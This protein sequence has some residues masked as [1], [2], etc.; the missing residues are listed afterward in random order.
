[1]HIIVY[2]PSCHTRYQLDP[3]LRGQHMRCPN[4]VCREV[5]E[6]QEAVETPPDNGQNRPEADSDDGQNGPA[7][8]PVPAA[9]RP[10]SGNVADIL[11]LLPAEQVEQAPPAPPLAS[12]AD[13]RAG[14]RSPR[15][16]SH[17]QEILPLL[18]AEA[19]APV[20][21]AAP[22]EPAA[23]QPSSPAAEP[24]I[25]VRNWQEAPPPLR[26]AGASPPVEPVPEAPPSVPPPPRRSRTAPPVE[27]AALAPPVTPPPAPPPAPMPAMELP[28]TIL[29]E[30]APASG[31]GPTE[32]LPGQWE[33]PPVR[34]PVGPSSPAG[35]PDARET[36]DVH[37]D[38]GTSAPGA[39]DTMVAFPGG[40]LELPL[41]PPEGGPVAEAAH[42]GLPASPAAAEHHVAVARAARRRNLRFIGL[43]V[44][45]LLLGIGVVV[46][47]Y[48]KGREHTLDEVKADAKKA[49]D[50]GN[51]SEA[52]KLY[53]QLQESFPDN[54]DVPTWAFMEQLAK[55][56]DHVSRASAN[57][58]ESADE[59]MQFI[60]EHEKDPLLEEFK[61][62]IWHVVG[63]LIEDLAKLS[64][65]KLDP[66]LLDQ[67]EKLL[68][69]LAKFM[70]PAGDNAPFLKRIGGTRVVLAKEE[71]RKRII[72]YL[73]Q[74]L[75]LKTLKAEDVVD[76]RHVV[77]KEGLHNDREAKELLDQI[78]EAF[79]KQVVYLEVKEGGELPRP[80][81][82]DTEPALLVAPPVGSYHSDLA[83]EG[84]VR[85]VFALARGVLW[86]LDRSDGHVRW[87]TRV[88]LD[89]TTLPI[90]LPAKLSAPERVLVL[91][92]DTNT[93]TARD[94]LYGKALW[95]HR[96]HAPCLSRPVIVEDRAYIPTITGRI[97]EI[98]IV[99]GTLLGWYQLG[100]R[101]IGGIHQE[102]T[103]LIY[104]PAESRSIYVIDVVKK[105]CVTVLQT[106]HP[107]A[108]LR[109]EPVIVTWEDPDAAQPNRSS[110]PGYLILCQTDGLDAMK[111][112]V[113]KLPITDAKAA[114]LVEQRIQGWSSLPPHC[115]GES[116]LLATDAGML[117]LFGIR[118]IRNDDPP[119]FPR[120]EQINTGRAVLPGEVDLFPDLPK[121][122]HLEDQMRAGGAQVIPVDETDFCALVR[123]EL[124]RYRFDPYGQKVWPLWRDPVTQT[125]LPLHLGSPLHGSQFD[126]DDQTLVVV[127]QSPT[128]QA[129]LAT[130]VD[131]R[132]GKIH[133]QRQLGLVCQSE[134]R[135]VVEARPEFLGVLGL[136]P[137]A[138]LP[139]AVPW[140]S[141]FCAIHPGVRL[142]GLD[143]GGGLFSY[144][145][146]QFEYRP[147]E[148]WQ[149][150]SKSL[151]NVLQKPKTGPIHLLRGPG[152]QTLYAIAA[153]LDPANKKYELWVQS[154]E[155][156][157]PSPKPLV[158]ELPS[159]LSGT[160][161]LLGDAL[162]L[163]LADGSLI[164]QPLQ[165]R[166][167]S[168][169]WPTWRAK[170]AHLRSLGHVVALGDG[171]FVTTDG[172]RT[173]T[174]WRPGKPFPI[175]KEKAELPTQIGAPPVLVP[176]AEGEPVPRVCVAD[177]QG[178]VILLRGDDL[179]MLQEWRLGEMGGRVTAGP[180]VREKWIGCIVDHRRLVWLDPAQAKPVWAYLSQEPAHVLGVSTLG[181]MGLHQGAG[182]LAATAALAP[183][184]TGR[185]DIVGHPQ[186]VGDRLLVADES[187]RFV[188]LDP[189]TG[190]PQGKGYTLRASVAPAV[191]PVSFGPDRAFAPL[192]DGTVL[193]LSL[194]HFR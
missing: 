52:G 53:R 147:N 172:L 86:A 176:P 122:P 149:L 102:E 109:S 113:F 157:R 145:S 1:V 54:D 105:E 72:D 9:P 111:L 106:E 57:P 123:G 45:A 93:L 150:S 126:E 18:D 10:M 14:R 184:R 162:V 13:K 20:E 159:A 4:P 64:E 116:L 56:R 38:E 98:E 67:A 125:P 40:P 156:G 26:F 11:P 79:R 80:K 100:E 89:M 69:E 171:G 182:P 137:D 27:P 158:F 185:G 24:P 90:R 140:A 74:L 63:K 42:P 114:P 29:P 33:A 47:A 25:E 97:D 83:N 119:L 131:A 192:T 70:P 94:I 73:K 181:L 48:L 170:R 71:K 138:A 175:E 88:G 174:R 60:K 30:S 75:A 96:L 117:G 95:Q 101:L 77:E 128:G 34:Q 99:S 143:Q 166:A 49:Y 127:T 194:R 7:V 62:D 3:G 151:A 32:L 28:P 155:G 17:V 31:E 55:L 121:D 189:A 163:P 51:Y 21:P 135:A 183:E 124:Q 188:G 186:L 132:H 144:D 161:G 19:V 85:V 180:F 39:A 8:D 134:P 16:S 108:S 193:L 91:S 84:R 43:L 139:V 148:E 82:G 168:E 190:K 146:S 59:V 22:Q 65:Q 6:V 154:W 58:V 2:C 160:P 187:G 37:R 87:A 129:C 165:E 50:E 110:R 142:V 44:L 36:L 169:L 23:W 46:F 177:S 115:D 164:Y 66:S 61:T 112:R 178:T 78:D 41:Y 118:Q 81:P 167:S 153:T 104:F 173:L 68:P 152:G 12:A 92:S 15:S 107:A 191:A 141:A 179:T 5:F 136:A 130:A 103:N 120:I 76:A 35:L 133:W